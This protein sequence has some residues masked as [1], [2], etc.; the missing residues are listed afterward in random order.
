MKR[1]SLRS[2]YLRRAGARQRE[3]GGG[4]FL[5]RHDMDNISTKIRIRTNKNAG[6]FSFGV[7][8]AKIDLSMPCKH[9]GFY[10]I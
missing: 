10:T 2:Y 3:K 5:L 9:L 4:R 1:N 6:G 8:F 7:E